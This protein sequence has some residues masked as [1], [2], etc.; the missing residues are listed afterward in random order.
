MSHRVAIVALALSVALTLGGAA[1]A[2]AQGLPPIPPA[3]VREVPS[4][5]SWGEVPELP[6]TDP[7]GPTA[8]TL[9]TLGGA[10]LLT[11]LPLLVYG[12]VAGGDTICGLD[13]CIERPNHDL[14]MAG[15]AL[16][17]GGLGVGLLSVPLTLG[18]YL[19]DPRTVP[20][21]SDARTVTGIALTAAGFASI[22]G[23]VAVLIENDRRPLNR[24]MPDLPDNLPSP[25]S[26]VTFGI[27][28]GALLT[29]SGVPLWISGGIDWASIDDRV[30]R[31]EAGNPTYFAVVDADPGKRD[32]GMG[33]VIAGASTVGLGAVVGGVVAISD[34][35]PTGGLVIGGLVAGTGAIIG[36]VGAP[37]WASG[38]RD[39]TVPW[40]DPRAREARPSASLSV[41][42]SG[43][44]LSGSF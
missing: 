21:A 4:S 29:V 33:L 3:P 44:E 40:D 26:W 34:L 27:I 42:P 38:A 30:Q 9:D 18:Y 32:E 16:L 20:R 10:A 39:I 28:N 23:S 31:D 43:L 25:D 37:I 24:T 41:S 1:P 14:R 35:G 6:S 7:V 13:G 12:N 11:G 5:S 36:I 19:T 17:G 15:A 8:V 2:V 22:G